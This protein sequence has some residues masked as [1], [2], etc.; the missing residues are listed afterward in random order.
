MTKVSWVSADHTGQVNGSEQEPERD[1]ET[2]L[3]QLRAERDEALARFNAI[4]APPDETNTMKLEELTRE[5]L[6]GLAAEL[7][8]E[9]PDQLKNKDEVI[10]AIRAAEAK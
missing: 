3:A 4:V 2:E 10:A 8:I 9:H 7:K 5:E 1:Y 6:N